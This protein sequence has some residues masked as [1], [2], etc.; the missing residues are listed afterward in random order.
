MSASLVTALNRTDNSLAHT[1]D[2]LASSLDRHADR[3]VGGSGNTDDGRYFVD[4]KLHTEA[5]KDVLGVLTQLK[6]IRE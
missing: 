5:I 4:I 6:S 1:L 2:K 3:G